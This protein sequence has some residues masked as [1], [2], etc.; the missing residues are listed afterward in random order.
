MSWYFRWLIWR[1]DSTAMA[2]ILLLFS[3]SCGQFFISIFCFCY[4]PHWAIM[5]SIMIHNPVEFLN[6][7]T[8]PSSPLPVE[9][10]KQLR[11]FVLPFLRLFHCFAYNALKSYCRPPLSP[12]CSLPCCSLMMSTFHVPLGHL[13]CNLLG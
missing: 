5:S 8:P 13:E 7:P 12:S 11:N 10:S 3:W 1:H 6:V 2:A 9:Q 4:C